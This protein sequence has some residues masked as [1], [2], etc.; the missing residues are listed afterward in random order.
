VVRTADVAMV[1][2]YC[3]DGLLASRLVLD[4]PGPLHVFYDLDTPV[5]LAALEAHGLATPDGARYLTPDLVPAFDLYLSFTGGAILDELRARWGARQ[6][7]PLY[8]SVD[9]ERHAPVADPPDE[10]RCDLGYLGT[11]AAD[12]QA[13]LERLLVEPARRRPEQR[14][15]VVGSLYP[16][17]LDWPPNVARREH[18]DPPRHP[19]FYSACRLTLNVTRPSMARFGY[20]PSG[21]LFEAASCGSPILS[22][23]WP[24]L[25][26]F[27]EPGAEILVAGSTDE[28]LA[29]LDLS[30]AEL[31]RIARAARE[32]T[33]AQHTGACRTRELVALCEAAAHGLKAAC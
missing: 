33:L 28:A 17:E 11:Y 6:V 2:S 3:P 19:A 32:R 18:L 7:A 27:F 30:D 25:D 14:F 5:T 31:S 15:R 21:R 10:L 29:A 22:D 1:T 16:A 4:T 13:G 20:A 12:R 24:G 9:P 26:A 23:W 8:G